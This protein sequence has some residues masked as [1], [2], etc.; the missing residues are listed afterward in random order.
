MVTIYSNTRLFQIFILLQLGPL[1]V[2]E[3]IKHIS[4]YYKIKYY[5]QR[6]GIIC[7]WYNKHVWDAGKRH[8]IWDK[9]PWQPSSQIVTVQIIR[10]CV[11]CG[12]KAPQF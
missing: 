3:F 12:I 2:P 9:M 11:Y 10:H 6:K 7:W 8:I 1:K 4:L 5:L